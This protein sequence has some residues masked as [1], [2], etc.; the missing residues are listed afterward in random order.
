M[1]TRK[2]EEINRTNALFEKVL[3]LHCPSDPAI[4]LRSYIRNEMT[5]IIENELPKLRVV[6]RDD[7]PIT[8]EGKHALNYFVQ[9]PGTLKK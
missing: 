9:F 4:D 8:A 5:K 2:N 7:R 3:N 1:E 6:L